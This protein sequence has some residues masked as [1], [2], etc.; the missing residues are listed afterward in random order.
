MNKDEVWDELEKLSSRIQTNVSEREVNKFLGLPESSS[1]KDDKQILKQQRIK[2]KIGNQNS[3]E[4]PAEILEDFYKQK[5]K[6]NRKPKVQRQVQSTDASIQIQTVKLQKDFPPEVRLF[7]QFQQ[8]EDD[9]QL[10]KEL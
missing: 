10:K 4:E 6:Q 5:S 3:M 8:P 7:K 2:A 1:R 9:P